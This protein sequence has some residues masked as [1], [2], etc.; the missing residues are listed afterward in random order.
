M[1]YRCRYFSGEC[2]ACGYCNK[3]REKK[4]IYSVK[5]NEREEYDK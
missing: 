4:G 2:D 5:K 1:A 3:I